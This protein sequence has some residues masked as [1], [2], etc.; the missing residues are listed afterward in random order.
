MAADTPGVL[1]ERQP[2]RQGGGPAI[3]VA[4]RSVIVNRTLVAAIEEV[5]RAEGL[6]CQYKKP[7]FGSTNAGPIHR[8]KTG[9]P[10]GVVSVP[11]RY[12]HAPCQTMRLSD[13][14]GTRSLL[15]AVARNPSSLLASVG[16][17]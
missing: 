10:T 1:P 4:D 5:A 12:I 17:T 16:A 3:T 7:L 15:T 9:I 13:Y 6:S 14:Q 2:A 8:S 11:C